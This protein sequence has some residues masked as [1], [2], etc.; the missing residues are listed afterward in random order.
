M[1]KILTRLLS[2][3]LIY[4]YRKKI[5]FITVN[6]IIAILA[7]FIYSDVVEFLKSNS[8]SNYLVYALL[9][10]WLI[11]VISVSLIAYSLMPAKKQPKTIV[12]ATPKEPLSPI[13]QHIKSKVKL[14]SHGDMIIEEARQKKGV[15]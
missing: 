4:T 8:L 7:I 3:S 13:E 5:I 9:G 11:I 2:F 6:L 12:K 10:K 1:T 14:K 15:Y